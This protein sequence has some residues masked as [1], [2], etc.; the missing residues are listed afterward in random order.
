MEKLAGQVAE[1]TEKRNDVIDAFRG[2]AILSVMAFHYTVRWA[3]PDYPTTNIYGYHLAYPLFLNLGALGVELFFVISGLVIAMTVERSRDAMDFIAKRMARLYPAFLAAMLLTFAVTT[4][5]SVP[6]FRTS[7]WDLPANL[8][9]VPGE[10]H[11]RAVDGAYWSLAWELEFYLLVSIAFFFFRANFWMAITVLACLAVPLRAIG[12]HADTLDRLLVAKFAPLFL[13][14][15]GGWLLLL[16]RRRKEGS[17]VVA[18]AIGLYALDMG[19]YATHGMPVWAA[20]AYLFG[21]VGLMFVLLHTGFSFGPLTWI[22]R[23]SYSLYLIHE[24]IGVIIIRHFVSVGIPDMAA[25]AAAALVCI[26]LAAV[27]FY[28]VEGRG[29]AIFLRVYSDVRSQ[30][31]RPAVAPATDCPV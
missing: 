25:A 17:A 7:F 1:M 28:T 16:K 15:I 20:S 19:N 30:F 18:V 6:I 29:R 27:M 8:T 23:I 12:F 3:P 26:G 5:A 14:G 21:G 4:F 22:G 24:N 2:V 10:F 31:A 11:V 13:L 9:M